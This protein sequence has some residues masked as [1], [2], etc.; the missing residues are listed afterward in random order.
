[1]PLAAPFRAEPMRDFRDTYRQHYGFVWHALHR[2][3]VRADALEDAA[4]ETFIV[5]YRRRD[6]RSGA[7][8]KPWLYGI[9]RRV[10]SNHRRS[11]ARHQR[12]ALAIGEVHPRSTTTP[13][14]ELVHALD[15]FLETL[16]ARD[17]E[18][19]VLSEVEGMTG[20]ELAESLGTKV[21][22]VYSRLRRMKVALEQHQ[23][24][25]ADPRVTDR[26]VEE[27]PA[28]TARS[29]ALLVPLLGRSTAAIAAGWASSVGSMKALAIAAGVTV[30]VTAIGV[31]SVSSS[32]TPTATGPRPAALA[33][34]HLAVATV[35]PV[36][37][38]SVGSDV[39]HPVP[40]R[41]DPS[42]PPKA[43]P[44]TAPVART[45]PTTSDLA[46]QNEQLTRAT[47]LLREGDATAALEVLAQLRRE[48]PDGALR[49][50]RAALQIEALCSLGKRDDARAAAARFLA[51]HRRSPAIRRVRN[52]CVGDAQDP[53]GPDT[54][55]A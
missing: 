23:L 29:W 16:P 7:A 28:A 30:T 45:P 41:A 2:L 17:R 6:A 35:A 44:T 14:Y 10:A 51:D 54:Q 47:A 4:Q 15:R 52:S 5:A 24:V 46:R 22:T 39:P 34:E 19:F 21:N 12:K 53:K 9:A 11:A 27:R 31:G 42:S 43:A 18:L 55:G 32:P 33:A 26:V 40:P 3:G 25:P 49:D 8:M 20:P 1:M 36:R 13:D 50:L 37:P 38:P 48:F